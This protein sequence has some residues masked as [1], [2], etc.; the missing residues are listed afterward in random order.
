MSVV[1]IMKIH[2][3][4][5]DGDEDVIHLTNEQAH[6]ELTL[7]LERFGDA[8][9]REWALKMRDKDYPN[10]RENAHYQCLLE[11]SEQKNY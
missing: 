11:K 5:S 10:C 9:K 4:Y 8:S 3:F 2:F 1:L 6:R 7:F